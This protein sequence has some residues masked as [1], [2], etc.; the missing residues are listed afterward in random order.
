MYNAVMYRKVQEL[1]D[2]CTELSIEALNKAVNDVLR[3][4]NKKHRRYKKP[5]AAP[6]EMHLFALPSRKLLSVQ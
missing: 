1:S 3:A 2:S 6:Y 4:N 5:H